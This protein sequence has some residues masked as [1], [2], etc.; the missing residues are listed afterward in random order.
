MPKKRE[1]VTQFWKNEAGEEYVTM[2]KEL[3]MQALHAAGATSARGGACET[4]CQGHGGCD[5]SGSGFVC[6]QDGHCFS[7]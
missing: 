3:W 2:P 4:M 5:W 7:V 1:Q 6:C